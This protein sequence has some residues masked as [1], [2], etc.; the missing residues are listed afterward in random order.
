GS[1]FLTASS[2]Y[3]SYS[4]N[5]GATTQNITVNQSGV[6]SVI[7]SNGNNCTSSAS[8]T[9]NA[10]A[11]ASPDICMVGVDSL[12][13]SNL[14][15]WDKPASLE[16]DSFII[17]REG[18]VANQFD[19]LAAQPYS[20]FSTYIDG[21]SNPQQQSYRYKISLKDTCGTESLLSSYHKTI[22]LTINAGAGSTW[23]LIWNLY[24]GLSIPTYNIYRGTSLSS[25]ALL[26]SVSGT[27]SSY[28]DLTP[29][30][31]IVY[32]QIEA[33]HPSGGCNPTMRLI[34]GASILQSYSS[35]FSNIAD[36]GFVGI[37]NVQQNDVFTLYPNP[38]SGE[39]N[40]L[41]TNPNTIKNKTIEISN[42]LGQV[43]YIKPISVNG[44][45]DIVR[46]N[47]GSIDNGIYFIKVKDTQSE[48]T[49]RFVKTN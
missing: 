37:A 26:T 8:Y 7:V 27:N 23:N 48:T 28:T 34:Q 10:S 47:I 24:D 14:I 9:L 46:F 49:V 15:I 42:T 21:N 31:G 4:W 36:N 22:H 44:M 16:I 35:S 3:P 41:F 18:I 43:I 1:V 29:P 19:R 5:T 6:Y 20:S 40:I 30:A 33:V 25:M 38:G 13:G 17:Y 32:Y 12:T 39:V 11:A 45:N 2:G